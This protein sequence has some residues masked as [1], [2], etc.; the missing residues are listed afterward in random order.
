M[1][2]KHSKVDSQCNYKREQSKL[3]N[4]VIIQQQAPC[5]HQHLKQVEQLQ[6]VV[7]EDI[8]QAVRDGNFDHAPEDLSE[9]RDPS[10]SLAG[11]VVF[12]RKIFKYLA[13]YLCRAR[14]DAQ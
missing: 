12:T 7:K 8:L 10:A 2:H 11:H 5:N 14:D 4:G 3:L 1:Q 13:D 9:S 6:R